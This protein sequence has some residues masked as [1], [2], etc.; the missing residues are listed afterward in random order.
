MNYCPPAP[1][2]RS[3]G[4]FVRGQ[5]G[6]VLGCERPVWAI[7]GGP[8]GIL[9][10]AGLHR[11]VGP[12]IWGVGYPVHEVP[13]DPD[14]R[15]VKVEGPPV[16]MEVDQPH[17]VYVGPVVD[18]DQGVP[19]PERGLDPDRRV[20]LEHHRV[21]IAKPMLAIPYADQIRNPAT[22]PLSNCSAAT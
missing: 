18:E 13:H 8:R 10:G 22:L 14:I 5:E 20:E 21:C 9:A 12:G 17:G 2:L 6:F 4:P 15:A 3:T 16:L 11:P 7:L 19:F 1:N